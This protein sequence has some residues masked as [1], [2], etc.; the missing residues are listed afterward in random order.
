[1]VTYIATGI[2]VGITIYAA[3]VIV[4]TIATVV[5]MFIPEK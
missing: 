3:S 1:M 5:E 4:A 2:I